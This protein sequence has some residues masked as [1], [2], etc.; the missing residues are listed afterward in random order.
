MFLDSTSIL[1][2]LSMHFPL[3]FSFSFITSLGSGEVPWS[4][5]H[6]QSS[7]EKIVATFLFLALI[8][9]NYFLLMTLR[10]LV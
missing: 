5:P 3:V 4:E 2:P 9:G 8:L 1:H 6:K 7:S 10:K